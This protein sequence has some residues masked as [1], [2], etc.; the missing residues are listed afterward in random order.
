MSVINEAVRDQADQYTDMHV[1]LNDPMGKSVVF[2]ASGAGG[3]TGVES[4][5]V[6]VPVVLEGMMSVI[7]RQLT[8][9]DAEGKKSFTISVEGL[10]Y[11]CTRM[12]EHRYALRRLSSEVMRLDELNL[13]RQATD[14][15]LDADFRAGLILICGETGSGKSTTAQSAVIARLEK[16]GGYCLTAESPIEV[17]LEGFHGKGYVEQI[18]VSEAGYREE[19]ATA[20]RKF[21]AATRSMFFFGEVIEPEGASEL[22]RLIGRG[23]LV[24]TTI[25][26]KDE[27]TA[28]AMLVAFA[29]RGGE[30]YARQLVGSNLKAVIHQ[31]LVAGQPKIQCFK[32]NDQIKNTIANASVALDTL[33]T[34]ISQ[35]KNS[36]VTSVRR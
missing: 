11:R 6:R 7:A 5:P 31:K 18:D 22:V 8:S 16:F 23:H 19:I 15:L 1:D 36:A 9:A 35:I 28:I 12:R 27:I 20:M 30:T 17:E 24:I 21:P 26:A 3:N 10:R 2:L 33:S 13:S 25:H 4:Q 32:A 14:I 29:E 34:A